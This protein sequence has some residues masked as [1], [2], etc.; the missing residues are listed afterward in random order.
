MG[1]LAVAAV[2]AAI[3][4]VGSIFGSKSSS[5]ATRQATSASTAAAQRA[6]ELEAKSAADAL[7]FAREQEA[8][9]QA[10][11]KSTQD[12]NYNIWK[13]ENEWDRLMADRSFGLQADQLGLSREQLAQ[14]LMLAR[15]Q[16]AQSQ[17]QFDQTLG[18]N[19]EK[20]AYVKALEDARQTRLRPYQGMGVGSLA[21]L[22]APIP[23]AS[24]GGTIGDLVR[25]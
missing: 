6:A 19:R 24:G 18:F 16:M 25:G 20:Q 7:A 10:E 17:S 12:Y 21:Q 22:S 9:R 2:P 11:Y 4:A 3:G 1:A 5:N 14:S 15:E 13:Q 23:R 8:A